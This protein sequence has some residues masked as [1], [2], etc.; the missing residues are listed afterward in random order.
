MKPFD[1][2]LAK[3][4]HPIQTRKGDPARI[5]CYDRKSKEYPIVAL[6]KNPDNGL[7][8]TLNYSLDGRFMLN[9]SYKNLDLVMASTKKEGWVNIYINNY[10]NS[11]FVSC[12][13]IC[14]PTKEEALQHKMDGYV[15]TIK[16]NWE[17]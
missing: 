13:P 8:E 1:L 17:E 4:N 9:G 15:T 14:F 11:K 10:M 12:S 3:R 16:I 2:E 7:E 5:I 6:V